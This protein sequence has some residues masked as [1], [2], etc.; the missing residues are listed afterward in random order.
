MNDR[1]R[2]RRPAPERTSPIRK[3]DGLLGASTPDDSRTK[4]SAAAPQAED[5]LARSVELGYRVVD[6]YLTRGQEAAQRVRHGVYG[7][8]ELTQDVQSVASQL[9]RSASDFAGAWVEF[10]ALAGRDTV[11][12]PLGLRAAARES[13]R[14]AANG[15]P[16]SPAPAD[17]G[18][19]DATALALL[20]VRLSVTAGR[21]VET[22]LDVDSVPATHGIVA[23]QPRLATDGSIRIR[24][25]RVEPENDGTMR[26]R[27]VVPIDQSPGRYTGLVVDDTTNLPAGELTIVVPPLD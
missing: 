8:E 14:P 20:R 23:H 4:S 24:D 25:V 22:A 2:I 6:E 13:V 1:E 3:W 19:A 17:A 16:E 21:P 11:P 18:A 9:V 26:I 5:I 15:V 12:A 27:V 7:A 10:F